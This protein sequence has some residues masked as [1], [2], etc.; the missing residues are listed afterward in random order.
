MTGKPDDDGILSRPNS[1]DN[2]SKH[3]Y[4]YKAN[5]VDP[6]VPRDP[7]A[8]PLKRKLQSRH[9]QM[10]AIG[11]EIWV[12]P[13]FTVV[14]ADVNIQGLLD[15]DCWLDLAMLLVKEDPRVS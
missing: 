2:A 6:E 10:I 7:L 5:E 1:N 11:G 12:P 4:S 15:R 14:G 9:L 8:A 13:F 3:S